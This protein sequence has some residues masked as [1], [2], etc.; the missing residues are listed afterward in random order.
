MCFILMNQGMNIFRKKS[1]DQEWLIAVRLKSIFLSSLPQR[2][3]ITV[4]TLVISCSSKKDLHFLCATKSCRKYHLLFKEQ[5]EETLLW[6][7]I[8]CFSFFQKFCMLL[9]YATKI[10]P[11]LCCLLYTYKLHKFMHIYFIY[12]KCLKCDHIFGEPN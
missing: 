11:F 7:M 1:M 12:F 3:I 10:N 4:S 5:G 9:M 8:T 2:A 6:I